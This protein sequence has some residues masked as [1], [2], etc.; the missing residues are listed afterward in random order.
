MDETHALKHRTDTLTNMSTTM[1]HLEFVSGSP[2]L[3]NLLGI[4]S[5]TYWRLHLCT[6]HRF[7]MGCCRKVLRER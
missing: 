6:V 4:D 2:V 5:D 3:Q 1:S 7:G